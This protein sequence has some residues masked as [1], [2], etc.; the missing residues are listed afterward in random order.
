MGFCSCQKLCDLD[1]HRIATV[2]H[3]KCRRISDGAKYRSYCPDS[4]LHLRNVSLIISGR[5]YLRDLMA[6]RLV[7]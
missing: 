6:T 3:F 1:R 4:Y 7:C 5:L 2:A